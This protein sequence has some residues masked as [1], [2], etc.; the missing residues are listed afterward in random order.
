MAA[1]QYPFPSGIPA[2]PTIG[3]LRGTERSEPKYSAEPSAYTPPSALASQYPSVAVVE[4][5]S[6][7]MAT[8]TEAGGEA[9]GSVDHLHA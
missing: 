5:G 9:G 1:S 4:A 7:A 2:M 8:M 6:A 3:P